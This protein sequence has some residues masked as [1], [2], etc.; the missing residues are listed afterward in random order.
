MM[1]LN[2]S[3][4]KTMHTF[5]LEWVP[6]EKGYIHWYVDGKF[7]FGIEQEGLDEMR[8]KIPQ[9]PS[10]VILNTAISTSWGFPNPPYGC[11][12]YDCKDPEAKCGFNPGFCQSLPAEFFIDHVRVYQNKADPLQTLGC[13]PPDFPTRKFILAHEYRYKNLE[14]VHALKSVAPGGGACAKNGDCGEGT[15]SLKRCWCAENW[16]GPNCLVRLRFFSSIAMD[17]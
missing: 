9:E 12:E 1:S 7:R 2:D 14:D 3:Y 4:W 5:R 10:Y 15:C 8:S 13:N 6:G 11:T 17:W 16:T